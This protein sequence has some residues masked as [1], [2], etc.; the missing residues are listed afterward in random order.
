MAQYKIRIYDKHERQEFGE[1]GELIC[2]PFGDWLPFPFS[3]ETAELTILAF[4]GYV[5]FDAEDNPKECTKV[6]LSDGSILFAV[7][8]FDTFEKN[9]LENYIPLFAE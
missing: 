1:F 3:F 7:N 6:Y 9:Y 5:L 2:K 8:K 4:R